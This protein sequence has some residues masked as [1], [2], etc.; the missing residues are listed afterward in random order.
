MPEEGE[1]S[2]MA[3]L[4]AALKGLLGKAL[5]GLGEMLVG[6][7]IGSNMTAKLLKM[8]G[9][10]PGKDG[11]VEVKN[12]GKGN[13]SDETGF[14]YGLAL[15]STDETWKRNGTMVI[16]AIK[17]IPKNHQENVRINIGNL[18]NF[19]FIKNVEIEEP[20]LGATPDKQGKLPKKITKTTQRFEVV[21]AFLSYLAEQTTKDAI[22]SILTVNGL[23]ENKEEKIKQALECYVKKA[24]TFFQDVEKKYAPTSRFDKFLKFILP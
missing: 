17:G 12:E 22:I 4:F 18:T 3:S 9:I 20:I 10:T 8:V 15:A 1:R 23:L 2:N 14:S 24:T 6:A 7:I 16:E 5:P 19:F 13:F 11:G 21:V